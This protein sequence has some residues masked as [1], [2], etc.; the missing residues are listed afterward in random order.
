[1]PENGVFTVA[2]TGAKP[3]TN[4]AAVAALTDDASASTAPRSDFADRALRRV[5]PLPA[6]GCGPEARSARGDV[7][8]VTTTGGHQG[9]AFRD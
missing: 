7:E 5:R 1:M 2:G 4:D 9:C 6:L 8:S 3:D